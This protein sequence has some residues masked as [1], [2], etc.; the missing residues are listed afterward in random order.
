MGRAQETAQGAVGDAE[1][2]QDLMIYL[3]TGAEPGEGERVLIVFL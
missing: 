1:A 2:L 3:C